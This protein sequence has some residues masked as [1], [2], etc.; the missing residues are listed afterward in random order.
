MSCHA[1]KQRF[2]GLFRFLC[3]SQPLSQR[4][5][6]DIMYLQTVGF[7][8]FALNGEPVTAVLLLQTVRVSCVDG[9]TGRL[10][11]YHLENQICLCYLNE[12]PVWSFCL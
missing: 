5:I 11:D 10:D 3:G 6:Q 9:R 12:G 2:F 7:V 1:F 8:A 4:L